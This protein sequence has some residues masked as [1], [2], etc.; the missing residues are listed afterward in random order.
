MEEA[1]RLFCAKPFTWFEVSRGREEGEVFLCCPGWLKRPVGNLVRQSVAET[2]NGEA[3][4]DIRRSI[5]DGSFEYCDAS[6]C[7]HIQEISGPVQRIQDVTDPVLRGVIREGLT[8][9]P[10]GPREV[11]CAHDRSCN[12]S[13]PSCRTELIIETGRRD[14]ILGVQRKLA[15]EA[16]VDAETLYITGSGDPFGSPFFRKWLQTMRRTDMPRLRTL[17]LHTNG[18]L[19]TPQV[20]E[21]IPAEI[22]ALIRSAEI[23]IDAASPETYAVNRRGG[24]FETLLARLE[25]IQSLRL[26][27]PLERLTMSMVVQENNFQ[28][29]RE[30]VH[31]GKR[32][33]AD[34]AYFSRLADWGTFDP[35]DLRNRSVHRA[36]HPRHRALLDVL[37]DGLFDD[38]I[39]CL[40][41]LTELRR[42]EGAGRRTGPGR[43]STR[44]ETSVRRVLRRAAKLLRPL[45]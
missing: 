15:Q 28:Q 18:L 13:C 44:A 16:L 9:L 37:S 12:L 23:S 6:L 4:Q 7:P 41:N 25:F 17:H 38:P 11:N 2:W 27:G 30:F 22:R 34:T 26:A 21:T 43:E 36:D 8:V 24:S 32:F 14:E 33:G 1:G 35:E 29:M 40:G 20:W 42:G 45:W 3:A 10:Y 19:W 39:V 5:L 31:L